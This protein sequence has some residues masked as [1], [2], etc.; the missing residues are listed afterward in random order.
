MS[1]SKEHWSQMQGSLRVWGLRAL[2]GR[3]GQQAFFGVPA[4]S[5]L[6]PPPRS[7]TRSTGTLITR[8]V[9]L[10][11]HTGL[12]II[13][14]RVSLSWSNQNCL[15]EETKLSLRLHKAKESPYACDGHMPVHPCEDMAAEGAARLTL[16]HGFWVTKAVSRRADFKGTHNKKGDFLATTPQNKGFW[17]SGHLFD[18]VR[19]CGQYLGQGKR[20]HSLLGN[21]W[22]E[23]HKRYK[24]RD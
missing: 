16:W 10:S 6:T 2:W 8:K 24:L 12:P 9:C 11:W 15:G 20:A 3:R 14:L 19:K 22:Q 23:S 1:P 17:C 5:V 7:T 18:M 13:P 4:P 21:V